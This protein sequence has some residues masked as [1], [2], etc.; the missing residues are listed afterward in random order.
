MY[1]FPYQR[2]Q[3]CRPSGRPS[4]SPRTSTW[5]GSVPSPSSGPKVQYS[6]IYTPGEVN[7]CQ[8]GHVV[9]V[10]PQLSWSLVYLCG[11]YRCLT[12]PPLPPRSGGAA[13]PV[14]W[15]LAPGPCVPRGLPGQRD[16][17]PPLQQ[18]LPGR[19][20]SHP[21]SGYQIQVHR[22]IPHG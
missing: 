20:G 15:P 18:G 12:I 21:T 13:G 4:D 1:A 3:C 6:Y 22:L 7:N 8:W 10:S 5:T 19:R 2:M 14:P 16:L 17:P 9:V 11:V